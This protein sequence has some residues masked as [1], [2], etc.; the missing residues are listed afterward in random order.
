MSNQKFYDVTVPIVIKD[1]EGISLGKEVFL[2]HGFKKMKEPDK[3]YRMR[4]LVMA[5]CLEGECGYTVDTISQ[6]IRPND[7]FVLRKGQ[8][9]TDCWQSPDF[10]GYVA[11]FSY[12]FFDE[13]IKGMSGLSSLFLFANEHA[14]RN[15]DDVEKERLVAYYGMIKSTIENEML[16]YRHET[17][18]ALVSALLY[19]ITSVI[20]GSYRGGFGR[21]T[22]RAHILELHASCGQELQQG[23][24]CQLV[25]R[26]DR[27]VAKISFRDGEKREQP[28]SERV[29]RLLCDA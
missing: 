6:S 1:C 2:M 23:E 3:V 10:R 24:A 5:V 18:Q 27:T 13:A 21:L 25:Q 7:I 14:V 9:V 8:V 19:D 29:D 28:H 26:A 12:A 15:I 4:C 22:C 11:L 16:M 20:S 17:V